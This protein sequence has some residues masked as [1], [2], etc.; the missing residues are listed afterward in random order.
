M[1][2]FPTLRERERERWVLKTTLSIRLK[3]KFNFN[4]NTPLLPNPKNYHNG[5]IL[6]AVM[7]KVFN[8]KATK[9]IKNWDRSSRK[10]LIFLCSAFFVS[11]GLIS[12]TNFHEKK[13][14]FGGH[15][16]YPNHVF[17]GF[18]EK[19]T[20]RAPKIQFADLVRL[21]HYL[22]FG[23]PTKFAQFVKKECFCGIIN[24]RKKIWQLC[25][26]HTLIFNF[27]HSKMNQHKN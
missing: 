23:S 1:E 20:C 24:L 9:G 12:E 13:K 27:S 10:T 22:K 25:I 8:K 26:H 19:I 2:N 21:L 11:G 3:M 17:I 7:E 18:I 15:A 16:T 4:L 14:C 5:L 6:R